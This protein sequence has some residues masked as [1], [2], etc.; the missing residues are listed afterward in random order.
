VTDAVAEL[1]RAT[2][3]L[4][5]RARTQGSGELVADAVLVGTER[6]IAHRMDRLE[7]R[8]QAAAKR[9]EAATMRDI[10]TARGALH[11]LGTRQE[12]A[13]NALPILARHGPAL[14]AAMLEQA[15][16]HAESLV[17]R[18]RPWTP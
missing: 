6:A 2:R 1:R 13:L 5:D 3:E 9:R 18:G 11:P 15:R 7:R 17:S 14:W 4:L 8:L 10:G 16:R 12:R